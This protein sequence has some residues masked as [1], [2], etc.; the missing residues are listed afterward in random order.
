MSHIVQI[1]TEV[2][3]PLAVEAACRRLALPP[4]VAGSHQL[5]SGP[6]S[7]LGVRLPGW[8]YPAV[9][10]LETGRVRFDHFEGR[11]GDP[12]Q[13]DRFL[14]GYSVERVLLEA[15][16][17]GHRVTEQPLADGSI[18]LTVQVG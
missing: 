13:L 17:R 1:E 12:A 10:E 15:R 6:V 4:P 5:Y 8:R 9:C 18:R 16:R 14:Q 7:G 11:W 3:D 2:R